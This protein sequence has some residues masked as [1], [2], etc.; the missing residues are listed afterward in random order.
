MI[1]LIDAARQGD[2]FSQLWLVET[3]LPDEI[4]TNS[5]LDNQ[6]T[7]QVTPTTT[8][9]V[10]ISE[11]IAFLFD[12]PEQYPFDLFMRL[13]TALWTESPQEYCSMI[14]SFSEMGNCPAAQYEYGKY[15]LAANK[16][17]AIA[18]IKKAARLGY[19]PAMRYMRAHTGSEAERGSESYVYY[20]VFGAGV[21][22]QPLY[23]FS[24]FSRMQDGTF[25]KNEPRFCRLFALHQFLTMYRDCNHASYEARVQQ[26]SLGIQT[27]GTQLKIQNN[28][29]DCR[30]GFGCCGISKESDKLIGKIKKKIHT[31]LIGTPI[32]SFYD[33]S[34]NFFLLITTKELCWHRGNQTHNQK[35]DASHLIDIDDAA[36]SQYYGC[37]QSELWQIY[38]VLSYGIV[39]YGRDCDLPTIEKM[40]FCGNPYAI[41]HMLTVEGLSSERRHLW[42][43]AKANWEAHGL[44]FRVCPVCREQRSREDIF[45]P[46]CGNKIN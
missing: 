41:N 29:K 12:R 8:E 44:F 35:F 3:L 40:A 20:D 34:L 26:L 39:S 37:Y 30:H 2:A 18:C 7:R 22:K 1:D 36:F 24:Y 25:L 15:W 31:N 13:R 27:I 42:E 46:E 21:F 17:A 19:Y 32:F 11:N 45:C 4:L 38:S 16:T 14:S 28:G 43:Q 10:Q 33:E 5:L 9:Q 23:Q 6:D